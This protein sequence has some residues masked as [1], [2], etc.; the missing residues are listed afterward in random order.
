ML[1][2]AKREQMGTLRMLRKERVQLETVPA[3]VLPCI[4][5]VASEFGHPVANL[6]AGEAAGTGLA[7]W[8]ARDLGAGLTPLLDPARD[9]AAG[10]AVSIGA[11]IVPTLPR[12]GGPEV[13][14]I[15]SAVVP[16]LLPPP[17]GAG[18]GVVIPVL[19]LPRPGGQ[20]VRIASTTIGDDPGLRQKSGLVHNARR[21]VGMWRCRG[22]GPVVMVMVMV[23]VHGAAMMQRSSLLFTQSTQV[24]W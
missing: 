20:G 13:G 15:G 23:L 11:A 1:V 12:P 9:L 2:A 22:S 10:R 18:I 5:R 21:A 8:R 3:L 7:L 19:T 14:G 4:L 16:V 6:Q 17:R 24:G